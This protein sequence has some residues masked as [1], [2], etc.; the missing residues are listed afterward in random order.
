[1][2][3]VGKDNVFLMFF[4]SLIFGYLIS[5]VFYL[6]KWF[7]QHYSRNQYLLLAA[8]TTIFTGTMIIAGDIPIEFMI[9]MAAFGLCGIIVFLVGTWLL[10][11]FKNMYLKEYIQTERQWIYRLLFVILLANINIFIIEF[12][13][14]VLQAFFESLAGL[15]LLHMAWLSFT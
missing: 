11:K 4:V 13:S 6:L 14:A 15:L 10:W 5:R 7:K 9:N 12:S 8:L 3:L 1:M 2:L